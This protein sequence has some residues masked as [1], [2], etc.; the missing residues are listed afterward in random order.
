MSEWI[1]WDSKSPKRLPPGK[2][3]V[4]RKTQS[5]N[6]VVIAYYDSYLDTWYGVGGYDLKVSAWMPLPKPYTEEKT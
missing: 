1:P 3:L 6:K 4:T 5:L 2:C